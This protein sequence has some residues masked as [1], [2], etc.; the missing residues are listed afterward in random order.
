MTIV[1][2]VDEPPE[3]GDVLFMNGIVALVATGAVASTDET[4]LLEGLPDGVTGGTSL[5]TGYEDPGGAV[6][7]VASGCVY[8][9]PS[10]IS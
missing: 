8:V 9:V 5:E 10:M 3:I 2:S 1:D 6:G 4:E 7:P